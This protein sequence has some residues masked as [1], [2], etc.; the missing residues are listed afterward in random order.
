[1]SDERAD[2]HF[3]N[4]AHQD[5][6]HLARALAS[7]ASYAASVGDGAV[8]E[9]CMTSCLLFCLIYTFLTLTCLDKARPHNLRNPATIS[10]SFQQNSGSL[11]SNI[12]P[13]P[14]RPRCDGSS[15][16]SLL[17]SSFLCPALTPHLRPP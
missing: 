9:L 1:M 12:P 2:G 8:F 14:A 7:L 10:P 15:L 16:P 6:G 17:T 13:I 3:H 11:S 5:V 4:V